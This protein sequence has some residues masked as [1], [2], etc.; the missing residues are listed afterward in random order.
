MEADDDYFDRITKEN[1]QWPIERNLIFTKVDIV[2]STP[3]S[4][5][6]VGFSEQTLNIL[7]TLLQ[8]AEKRKNYRN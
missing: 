1:E 8:S 7:V 6:T 4:T 2:I 3:T 5:L